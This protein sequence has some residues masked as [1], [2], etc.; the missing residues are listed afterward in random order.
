MGQNNSTKDERSIRYTHKAPIHTTILS[1]YT[2]LFN[3]FKI[4]LGV[5][6]IKT[7]NC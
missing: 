5:S 7:W 4:F 2:E 6:S 3:I 1:K